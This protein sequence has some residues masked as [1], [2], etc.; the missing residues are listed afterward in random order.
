MT[1]RLP[2]P[3][4]ATKADIDDTETRCRGGGRESRGLFVWMGL[5]FATRTVWPPDD[6]RDAEPAVTLATG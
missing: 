3:R 1:G 4:W 6:Q 2:W 5:L